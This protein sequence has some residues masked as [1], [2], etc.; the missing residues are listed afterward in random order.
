MLVGEGMIL[1]IVFES[2]IGLFVVVVKE[3]KV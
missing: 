2:V 1:L 3:K